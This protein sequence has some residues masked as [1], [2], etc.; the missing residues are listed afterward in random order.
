MLPKGF[1]SPQVFIFRHWNSPSVSGS[2]TSSRILIY[3]QNLFEQTEV[4]KGDIW[5][6]CAEDTG[7]VSLVLIPSNFYLQT[8]QKKKRMMSKICSHGRLPT[9]RKRNWTFGWLWLL[10][11]RCHFFLKKICILREKKKKTVCLV[12][13]TCLTLVGWRAGKKKKNSHLCFLVLS[14]KCSKF[15]QE[16]LKRTTLSLNCAWNVK[17]SCV[18]LPVELQQ[19]KR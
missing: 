18:S 2:D 3:P 11:K 10:Q 12:V 4:P 6:S 14:L 13:Q 7:M 17:G 16:Q 8:H 1:F 5:F 19:S 15:V 9:K